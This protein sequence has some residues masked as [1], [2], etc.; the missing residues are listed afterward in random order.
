MVKWKPQGKKTSWNVELRKIGEDDSVVP[1]DINTYRWFFTFLKCA[2]ELNGTTFT[3]SKKKH[4][5]QFDKNHPWWKMINL[6][7]IPTEPRLL[8][9][10]FKGLSTEIDR[11]FNGKLWVKY[12]H[13]FTNRTTIVGNAE[14]VPEDFQSFH[15]PPDYSTRMK[16]R[17]IR[18]FSRN[19]EVK[20]KSGR[21]VQR[22]KT[23]AKIDLGDAQEFLMRR[24][25]H[26][27][28]LDQSVKLKNIDLFFKVNKILYK[29]FVIP[30]IIRVNAYAEKG[31]GY[32]TRG[33]V[34]T[35]PKTNIDKF[36]SEIRMTQRDRRFAKILIINLSKGVFPKIDK[37]I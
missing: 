17:V 13:L 27:I 29:K 21:K 14:E 12:K 35:R 3:I 19:Q 15:F 32:A 25:F 22:R 34:G 9:E 8:R 18:E 24:L 30:E 26:T 28:R 36:E 11:M 10:E 4:K 1:N 7:D 2:K 16:L 31:D 37:V 20:K 6:K 5:I 33:A 23:N